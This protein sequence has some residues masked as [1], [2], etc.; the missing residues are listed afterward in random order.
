MKSNS[1][2]ILSG[3]LFNPQKIPEDAKEILDNFDSL[4]QD[5]LPLN[6]RQ[7]LKLP[8]DIRRLSHLLTDERDMRRL[9][10]MNDKTFLSAYARYFMW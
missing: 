7:I 2:S 4:I 3:S 1:N 10:Y 9:S 8:E 5:N 6:S